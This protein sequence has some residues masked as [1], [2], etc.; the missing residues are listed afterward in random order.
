MS[1]VTLKHIANKLNTSVSTVSRALQDHPRISKSQRD[2]INKMAV[3]LGYFDNKLAKSLKYNSTGLIG[4]II[5]DLNNLFFAKAISGIQDYLFEAGY[6]ML[7]GQSIE[8]IQ[9]EKDL[10]NRFL[11]YH[12]EGLIISCSKET[13]EIISKNKHIHDLPTIF[14]DRVTQERNTHKILVDDYAGSYDAAKKLI[15]YGIHQVTCIAGLKNMSICESRIQGIKDAFADH[16]IPVKHVTT[17]Y[18]N[19]TDDSLEDIMDNI[20]SN[21][22]LPEVLFGITD[23]I[24]IHILKFLARKNIQNIKVAGYVDDHY[25]GHMEE[26]M[27]RI[28]QPSYEI[29]LTA[30]RQIL[31]LIQGEKISY[32][33]LLKPEIV[34]GKKFYNEETISDLMN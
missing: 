15:E 26:N 24:T 25:L 5:P 7:M 10:I 21:R 9:R 3:E 2:K 17:C 11:S 4:V 22:K 32:N 12:V 31:K 29:G 28:F 34:V 19:L 20:F 14:F 13:S 33:E 27:I 23:R 8:T 30:A 16:N 18:S 6:E 1:I